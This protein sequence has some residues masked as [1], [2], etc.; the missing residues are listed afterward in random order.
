MKFAVTT[1]YLSVLLGVQSTMAF[2]PASLGPKTALICKNQRQG[3]APLQMSELKDAMHGMDRWTNML[4]KSLVPP[5]LELE[6]LGDSD[7]KAPTMG[8]D[9]KIN[10]DMKLGCQT[11]ENLEDDPT[12]GGVTK[13][14]FLSLKVLQSNLLFP[15]DDRPID[16]T[17]EEVAKIMKVAKFDRALPVPDI[18]IDEMQ[19][20]EAMTRIAFFGMGAHRVA[21]ASEEE[22]KDVEG[23]AFV[24]DWFSDVL[25]TLEVRPGFERYGTKAY[26]GSNLE[27]L[28]VKMP[29]KEIVTPSEGAAWEHAKFAWRNDCVSVVTVVD[30]LFNAHFATAAAMSIAGTHKLSTTNP[31]RRVLEVFLF[32]TELINNTAGQALIPKM[33]L[34]HHF[35][36]FT[37]ESLEAV[38]DVTYRKGNEWM[39]LPKQ[40]KAKGDKVGELV[41]KGELPYFE[42]GL[43]IFGIL[44][45]FM[46]KVIDDY[47]ENEAE[48]AEFWA[49]LREKTASPDLSET[50]TRDALVDA[51]AQFAFMV[52]M[53]HEHVGSITEYLTS[54]RFAGTRTRTQSVRVDAQAWLASACLMCLTGISVPKLMSG[55]S[56]YWESDAEHERWNEMQAELETMV[57]NVKSRNKERRFPYRNSRPDFLECAI[58]V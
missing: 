25:P 23:T 5:I 57:E 51:A 16:Y 36:A 35:T 21:E 3:N 26:F 28:G 34:V 53:H 7:L 4:V 27:P 47:E 12:Y 30:H 18:V 8:P 41:K 17:D 14:K 38:A 58:S 45:R 24:I 9:A 2:M 1:A 33:S 19:S 43:E 10:D 44:R 39:P 56:D 20:D 13:K 29:G 48:Y 6:A 54:P 22:K 52:T 40:L 11:F 32:R 37:Y 42:D 50:L 49:Y 31:L 15:I 46:D 55:F